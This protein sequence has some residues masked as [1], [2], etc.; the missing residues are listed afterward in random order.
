MCVISI[1]VKTEDKTMDNAAK[2][3]WVYYEEKIN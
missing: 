1:R 3:K 2:V